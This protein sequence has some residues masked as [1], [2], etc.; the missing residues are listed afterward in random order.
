MF[1]FYV[2]FSEHVHAHNVM[3]MEK[4]LI[5]LYQHPS[6]FLQRFVLN[7][8]LRKFSLFAINIL[9]FFPFLRNSKALKRRSSLMFGNTCTTS[10]GCAFDQ[11]RTQPSQNRT[12]N[13][14]E[15]FLCESRHLPTWVGKGLGI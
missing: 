12:P 8:L 11:V 13:T 9:V 14:K 3:K 15:I 2:K 4:C 6:L 5:Q 10:M 1:S 7:H